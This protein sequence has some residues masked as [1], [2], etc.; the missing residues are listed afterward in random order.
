MDTI[1]DES[2][3]PEEPDDLERGCSGLADIMTE[4]Q[5]GVVTKVAIL[6]QSI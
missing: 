5:F 6:G 2:E 3:W 1:L 4:K